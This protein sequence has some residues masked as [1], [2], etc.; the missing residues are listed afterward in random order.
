MEII[1][2][3]ALPYFNN[4]SWEPLR[5]DDEE[6]SSAPS[7]SSSA[8]SNSMMELQH[9]SSNS[10]SPLKKKHSISGALSLCSVHE[11]FKEYLQK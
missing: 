8:H 7:V 5:G 10:D 4:F 6:S 1:D 11:N 9:S 2:F 3:N